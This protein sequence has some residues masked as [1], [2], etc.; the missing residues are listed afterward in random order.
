MHRGVRWFCVALAL[1]LLGSAALVLA[2][3]SAFSRTGSGWEDAVAYLGMGTLILG[4]LCNLVA[5]WLALAAHPLVL[6][7][8][9]EGDST[10]GPCPALQCTPEGMYPRRRWAAAAGFFLLPSNFLT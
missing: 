5:A 9:L 10:S 2:I 6:F 3:A 1:S 7:S 8:S 4:G